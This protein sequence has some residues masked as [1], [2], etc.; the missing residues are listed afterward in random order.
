MVLKNMFFFNIDVYV[1]F[2]RI[3]AILARFWES[4]SLPK[5]EKNRKTSIFFDFLT[6]SVLKKG[7]G[8]VPGGFWDGF[9]TIL[10]GF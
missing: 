4:P 6:R 10:G 5:I 9:W 2:L 7:S 1:F 3:F 8:R